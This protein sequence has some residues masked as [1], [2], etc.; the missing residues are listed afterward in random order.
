MTYYYYYIIIA[1]THVNECSAISNLVIS[2][3]HFIIVTRSQIWLL[4]DY[5]M[6]KMC[7]PQ[8]YTSLL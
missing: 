8:V 5:N 2:T 3:M 4:T 7:L 6:C 1:K